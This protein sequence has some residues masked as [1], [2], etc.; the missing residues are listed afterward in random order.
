MEFVI[1]ALETSFVIVDSA[2]SYVLVAMEV[3]NPHF[4]V[5]LVLV[6][7]FTSLTAEDDAVD[8]ST[9]ASPLPSLAE[10]LA[11]AFLEFNRPLR[12]LWMALLLL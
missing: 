7:F 10:L 6:P 4:H 2:T 12:F 9:F 8:R 5:L 11:A 1:S 3:W